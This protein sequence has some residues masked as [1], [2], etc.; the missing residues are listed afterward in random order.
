MDTTTGTTATAARTARTS[1][2]GTTPDARP[3]L[4]AVAPYPAAG[5]PVVSVPPTA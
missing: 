4:R 2:G 5:T 1:I 3:A